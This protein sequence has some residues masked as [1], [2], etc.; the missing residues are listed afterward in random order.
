RIILKSLIEP[1]TFVRATI[2]EALDQEF[3]LSELD[4][5]E[6]LWISCFDNVTTNKEV[7]E[8]IWS[9]SGFEVD[10]TVPAK[11]IPFLE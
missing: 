1:N 4:F 11:L 3:D 9:E 7:A 5:N 2:L 6:E 8:T 10:E